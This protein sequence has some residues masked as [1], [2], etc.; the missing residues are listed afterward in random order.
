MAERENSKRTCELRHRSEMLVLLW[1]PISD[2]EETA[3][4][5]Q[6][7]PTRILRTGFHKGK[8]GEGEERSPYSSTSFKV[9]LR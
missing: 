4:A 6:N 7:V 1:E 5:D 8:G 2:S 9:K 3:F